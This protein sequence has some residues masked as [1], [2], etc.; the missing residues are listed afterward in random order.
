MAGETPTI[1][2][3]YPVQY[4][5]AIDAA[6][7]M[8]SFTTKYQVEGAEFV[9]GKTIMVPEIHFDGGTVP[10]NRFQTES[11]IKTTYTPY[12]LE[13]DREK[14]FYIDAIDDIDDVHI[15]STNAITEFERLYLVP[16]LDTYFFANVGLKAKTKATT[17]LSKTNIKAE[18]RKARFQMIQNGFS[19]ADL[20]MTCDALALLEDAIDRQFAGEGA[21]N[22][23]VGSYNM[24]RI[25]TVPD[26]RL[27]GLDFA[28]I[29]DGC[30]K[31]VMKR[32]ATYLFQPGNHTGGDGWI[33]Q[34]RWVYGN[35]SHNNKRGGLYVNG[36][37]KTGICSGKNVPSEKDPDTTP[38]TP[39]TPTEGETEQGGGTE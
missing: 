13:C 23:T 35:L 4:L 5:T 31:N 28:V 12:E 24:F 10:Y 27:A 17:K 8:S 30:I 19:S 11:E 36:T 25:Y 2:Q 15:R 14:S 22:D 26:D 9:R 39:T 34:L 6:V 38:T 37:V 18:L 20:Y 33:A 29:A 32:A 3:E 21:I 7:E 1:S 16:E